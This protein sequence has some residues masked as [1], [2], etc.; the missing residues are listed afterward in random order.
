MSQEIP[1]VLLE[2]LSELIESHLGLNF[3]KDRWRDIHRAVGKAAQSHGYSDLHAYVQQLLG[4]PWGEPHVELMARYLTIGET[5]FFRHEKVFEVLEEHILPE[6]AAERRFTTRHVRVWSAGCATGEEPYSIAMVLNKVLSDIARWDVTILATD[7]NRDHLRKAREAAYG[8]WSFRT[9]PP[10]IKERY[11]TE[12]DSRSE[13]IPTI[14]SMV[15]FAYLNLAKDAY[16]LPINDTHDMDVVF[17]RNVLM[18]FSPQTQERVVN[19]LFRSLREGGWLIVSPAEASCVMHPQLR[20][21]TFPGVIMYRKD[22]TGADNRISGNTAVF[23]LPPA[24][25]AVRAVPD[26]TSADREEYKQECLETIPLV[27]G[28][29]DR[30]IL[31]D[32]PVPESKEKVSP[33]ATQADDD[34]FREGEEFFDKGEYAAAVEKLL[35]GVERSQYRNGEVAACLALLAKALANLGKLEEALEW[36]ERSIQEDKLDPSVHH[37]QGTILQE[38]GRIEEAATAMTRAVFLDPNLVVAHFALGNLSKQRGRARDAERHYRVAL[39]I[40][41]AYDDETPVPKSGG[42]TAGRLVETI[43][44]MTMKE[45]V[46][47]KP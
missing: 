27:W 37:L 30:P 24:P 6:L 3:P 5:H 35:E 15:K 28:N 9:V 34:P 21:E 38:Q 39:K 41:D 2:K 29:W 12:N 18:Y 31:L 25:V 46:D 22:T 14:R 7:V 17:C 42:M 33:G 43:L 47:G 10:G 16:P 32:A 20:T 23:R 4:S 8:Q 36:A 26:F 19:N 13:V 1:E 11:F 44:A 45:T 40:L